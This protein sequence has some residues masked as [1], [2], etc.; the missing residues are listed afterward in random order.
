[1]KICWPLSSAFR[2]DKKVYVFTSSTQSI[3]VYDNGVVAMI[4]DVGRHCVER[5]GPQVMCSTEND[6]REGLLI[7]FTGPSSGVA[8]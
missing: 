3:Y 5:D 6:D 1:V 2:P 7:G 4:W 8:A